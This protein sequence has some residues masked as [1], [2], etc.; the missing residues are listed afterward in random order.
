MSFHKRFMDECIE[1]F[2]R[3]FALHPNLARVPTAWALEPRAAFPLIRI[4]FTEDS[5]EKITLY[6]TAMG[7][8][9]ALRSYTV[10]EEAEPTSA[11]Y[12]CRAC[13]I[14]FTKE[15]DRKDDVVTMALTGD[16]WAECGCGGLGDLINKSSKNK[17]DQ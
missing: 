13:G 8:V 6:H 15:V 14:A 3:L 11:T 10:P 1:D 5:T 9:R 2:V 17:A 7:L 12:Q 4:E 16:L